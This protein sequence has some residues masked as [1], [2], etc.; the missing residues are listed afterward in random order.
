MIK[1]PRCQKAQMKQGKMA[2]YCNGEFLCAH[3]YYCQETRGY[4][5]TTGYQ[6]CTRLVKQKTYLVEEA[7]IVTQTSP[8]APTEVS[9]IQL[10]RYTKN[11]IP[12]TE[13]KMNDVVAQETANT[14]GP[15]TEEPPKGN[16]EKETVKQSEGSQNNG[17]VRSTRRRGRKKSG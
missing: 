6:Q 5:N 10:H 15:V 14:A 12:Q 11:V 7:P 16:T 2:L 3:Q 8:E 9:Y 1:K 13:K 17:Q 4:E